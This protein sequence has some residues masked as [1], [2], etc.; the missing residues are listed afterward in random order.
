MLI[1][2]TKYDEFLLT[3]YHCDHMKFAGFCD[4]D[5]CDRV[6]YLNDNLSDK[7]ISQLIENYNLRT[8]GVTFAECKENKCLFCNDQEKCRR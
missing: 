2:T 5:D 6:D 1:N 4:E 8:F 7:Q 3:M